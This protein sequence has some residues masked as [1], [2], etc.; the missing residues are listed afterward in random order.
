MLKFLVFAWQLGFGGP[1]G[2]NGKKDY[3][4]GNT[5][6]EERAFSRARAKRAHSWWPRAKVS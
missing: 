2:K 3:R 1:G 6:S 5:A 4:G